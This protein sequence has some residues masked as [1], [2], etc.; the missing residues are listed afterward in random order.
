MGD[1]PPDPSVKAIS[2]Q[3]A[4]WGVGLGQPARPPARRPGCFTDFKSHGDGCKHAR[5]NKLSNLQPCYPAQQAFMARRCPPNCAHRRTDGRRNSLAGKSSTCLNYTGAR[6]GPAMASPLGRITSPGCDLAQAGSFM[7]QKSPVG[8]R[9]ILRPP[10]HDGIKCPY[11][12]TRPS[13]AA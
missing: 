10:N 5:G 9:L 1:T 3:P 11:F 12:T 7:V 13:L 2:S 4:L 6:L 8:P